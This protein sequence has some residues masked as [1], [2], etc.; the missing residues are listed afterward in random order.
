MPRLAVA[1]SYLASATAATGGGNGN[2]DFDR[3]KMVLL[4]LPGERMV[5]FWYKM[6]ATHE[7]SQPDVGYIIRG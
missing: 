5:L 7:D 6:V 1:S 2:R 4:Q 3:K